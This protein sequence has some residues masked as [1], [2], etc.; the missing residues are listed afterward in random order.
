MSNTSTNQKSQ[1]QLTAAN[2]PLS[3]TPEEI[4]H[5]ETVLIKFCEDNFLDRMKTIFW[6]VV[7]IAASVDYD[8]ID[9]FTPRE[10][11]AFHNKV[12]LFLEAVYIILPRYEGRKKDR[13]RIAV[14]ISNF[15]KRLT[16]E[17][18]DEPES[19]I[20]DLFKDYSLE[21]I[22][23]IMKDIVIQAVCSDDL[24]MT[25]LHRRDMIWFCEQIET[26]IEAV[27]IL[28]PQPDSPYRKD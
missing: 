8:N 15:P 11:L 27:Y 14:D 22:R 6:E 18:I 7:A 28:N 23:A 16:D 3:L 2:T 19:V 4:D 24:G 9:E 20:A 17:Q 1:G 25:S 5:P 26:L 21:D 13:K 12:D 10:M